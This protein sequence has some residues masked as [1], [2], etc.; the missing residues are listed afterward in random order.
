MAHV[1][2]DTETGVVQLKKFVAVQ[3][4]GLI[5]NPKLAESQVYGAVIM[6]IA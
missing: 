6:A 2:V 1:A 5:I 4:M 3:D